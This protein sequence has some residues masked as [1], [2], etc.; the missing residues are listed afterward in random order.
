[1]GTLLPVVILWVLVV[2]HITQLH[3][4]PMRGQRV[5][6]REFLRIPVTEST[7]TGSE[8]DTITNRQQRTRQD[9]SRIDPDIGDASRSYII[10][11]LANKTTSHEEQRGSSL[12]R[13]SSFSR[14]L[15]RP[16]YKDSPLPV[17]SHTSQEAVRRRLPVKNK[18]PTTNKVYHTGNQSPDSDTLKQ[19][20]Q[21]NS[22]S[23]PDN[24]LL[25][26]KNPSTKLYIE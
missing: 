16:W 5:Y 25:Q 2:T 12:F 13:S 23:S 4:S 24:F 17:S 6:G 19:N 10:A 14:S 18:T 9:N 21:N 26:K 3:G 20:S 11:Q 7:T 15:R 22:N 1:M 8:K